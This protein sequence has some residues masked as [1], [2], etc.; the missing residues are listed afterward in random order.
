MS[1]TEYPY[2]DDEALVTALTEC[3][4]A[5]VAEAVAARGQALLALAGGRTPLPVYRRLAECEVDWTRV[6]VLPSDERCVPHAHPACNLAALRDAFRRAQGLTLLPLTTADGDPDASVAL[7]R[8][9]LARYPQDFD[10]VLLGIGNDAHTASLFPGAPQ[11]AAALAPDAPDAMRIDPD[12]L[13]PEAPW[14]RITLSAARIK[15][16]RSVHLAITGGSKREALQ[17]AQASKDPLTTPVG[18]LLHADDLR[19]HVHWSP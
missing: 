9:T 8:D 16:A 3:L 11:L 2:R 15:R 13:P 5:Q 12:P 6:R 7:A 14:P 1:W 17:R 19:L 4:R 18:A 10:L